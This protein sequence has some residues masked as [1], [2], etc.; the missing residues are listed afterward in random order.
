MSTTLEVKINIIKN[1][2][3]HYVSIYIIFHK[4]IFQTIEGMQDESV[5]SFCNNSTGIYINYTFCIPITFINTLK[6]CF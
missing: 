3:I 6:A 5:W 2:N 1:V 4:K